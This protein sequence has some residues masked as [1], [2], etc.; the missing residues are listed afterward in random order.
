MASL[1]DRL[2]G[3]G[4]VRS[5]PNSRLSSPYTRP[6]RPPK[7]DSDSQWSHDLYEDPDKPSLSAR[8]TNSAAL[9]RKANSPLVQRALRDATGVGSVVSGGQL[10]IKGAS[11][12]SGGNVVQVEG[13]VKGT[14]PADVEAIF[15]RC[16]TILSSAPGPSLS[17]SA[18]E[19]AVR[20]T[21]KDPAAATAAV[22]KFDK[23]QAD[24]RTLRVRIVGGTTS[25]LVGR[26]GVVGVE[27]ARETGTVDVLMEGG[28]AGGSKLRSDSIVAS[29]PRAS[30]L[31]A[32]PGADPK[33]YSQQQRQDTQRWQRG[34]GNGRGRG[35]RRGGGR[36]GGN[37]GGGGM[38]VD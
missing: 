14:T 18:N 2:S 7:G 13:L 24:G 21:F 34:G 12:G 30:V 23:Q 27:I 36:R 38:D 10:S 35:G 4:P 25:S 5:K 31:V 19:V 8:L 11:G 22:E 32:P 3:A 28:D 16:G 17:H 9:P 15:K 20:V 33:L 29:D 1:L 37:G 6:S 26:L